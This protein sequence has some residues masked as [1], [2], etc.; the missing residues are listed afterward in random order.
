MNPINWDIRRAG[1]SWSSQEAEE[2]T[3]LIPDRLEIHHG[4]L[5]G[6]DEER[7]ISL[8][9]LLENLG[10]DLIVRRLGTR[11]LWKTAIRDL[12]QP[13]SGEGTNPLRALAD[14]GAQVLADFDAQMDGLYAELA[15]SEPVL[16]ARIA[17]KFESQGLATLLLF[18]PQKELEGKSVLR[19]WADGEH[20][21]AAEF[22]GIQL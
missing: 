11:E 16:A 1:R 19:L 5:Y 3:A 15:K 20:G 22:L 10:I 7:L 2:R 14:R 9:C 8:A 13:V 21:R 17:E 4:K 6:S 12:D 18:V